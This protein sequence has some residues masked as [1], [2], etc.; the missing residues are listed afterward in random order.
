MFFC[1]LH[2]LYIPISFTTGHI[3]FVLYDFSHIFYY[4][5]TTIHLTLKILPIPYQFTFFSSFVSQKNAFGTRCSPFHHLPISH[6]TKFHFTCF[7]K[8]YKGGKNMRSKI[9]VRIRHSVYKK[10]VQKI[11]FLLHFLLFFYPYC[12]PPKHFDF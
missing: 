3:I 5:Y 8:A 11:T 10:A 4:A 6:H 1:P 9:I 12:M 2:N 7:Q